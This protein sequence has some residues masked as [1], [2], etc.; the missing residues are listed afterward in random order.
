MSNDKREWSPQQQDA[1]KKV[2]EWLNDSGGNKV[3]R[4]FGY[5]GSG[6]STLAIE[7]ARLCDGKVQFAAFTGKAAR[8]MKSKGCHNATTIHSLIYNVIEDE[9]TQKTGTPKFTLNYDS[10]VKECKLVIIDEVSMVDE[11]L[12][13]DL[14]SFGKKILVLGDPEQLPPISGAGFFTSHTPDIM[15]TEVHRQAKDSPIINLATVVRLGGD[16]EYGTYGESRVI[17]R[18]DLVRDD[19]MDTDQ[20]IVGK[21]ATR[22]TFNGNVRRIK[23]IN[24]EIPIVGEKVICLRNNKQKK[25]LNGSMWTVKD[26]L[27]AKNNKMADYL[28]QRLSAMKLE[29]ED[30]GYPV[31]VQVRKEF[32]RGEEDK[33]EWKDKKY[34]DDFTFGYAI[35]AHKSQGS[36]WD[37][38]TLFDESFVFRDE[39]KRHLYT[40]ITRAAKKITIIR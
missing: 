30:D 39:A 3:F 19:I 4:L 36:Q 35:T 17:H 34:T 1:L 26:T 33:L 2:S 37:T 7:M 9:D 8:V 32:W 13:M 38:V 18:S 24:S 28:K 14:L 5:A 6:K 22:Q 25:I 15:L 12:G 10:P 40:A 20:I 29:S 21:N 23:G 16:L 11:A 31:E 27:N